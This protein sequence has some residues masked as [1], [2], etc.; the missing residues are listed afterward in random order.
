MITLQKPESCNEKNCKPVFRSGEYHPDKPYSVWCHGVRVGTIAGKERALKEEPS[1]IFVECW[2][3]GSHSE[4]CGRHCFV[5]NV[6]DAVLTLRTR[7]QTLHRLGLLRWVLR[8]T[9]K[10][11]HDNEILNMIEEEVNRAII[12]TFRPKEIKTGTRFIEFSCSC[13]ERFFR[14]YNHDTIDGDYYK[15]NESDERLFNYHRDL[16]HTIYYKKVKRVNRSRKGDNK[17]W[18]DWGRKEYKFKHI[19][20]GKQ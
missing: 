14:V 10:T 12:R 11:L 3:I 16:G 4:H 15:P 8:T 5:T 2:L 19:K 13:G 20:E 1:D 18:Q 6:G 7:L 9:F 17:Y